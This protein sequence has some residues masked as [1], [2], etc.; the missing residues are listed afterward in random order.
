[1]FDRL[2]TSLDLP[3][4]RLGLGKVMKVMLSWL[5]RDS[6]VTLHSSAVG[7]YSHFLDSAA[8][9][10]Q[11]GR[12]SAEPRVLNTQAVVGVSVGWPR[13]LQTGPQWTPRYR[14]CCRP[15]G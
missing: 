5:L 7:L 8:V 15:V 14:A 6:P 12:R 2:F 9:A 10:R 4:S 11:S 3:K 13:L 1:M